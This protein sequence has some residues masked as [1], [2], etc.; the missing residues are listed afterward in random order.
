V[1]VQ[2]IGPAEEEGRVL[3]GQGVDRSGEERQYWS[4]E[5]RR[6]MDRHVE[7]WQYRGG[8]A[9]KECTGL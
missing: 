6:G 3:G 7:E 2:G 1:E 4:A 5:L 9:V 8:P